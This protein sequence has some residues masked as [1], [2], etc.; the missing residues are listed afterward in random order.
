MTARI[1]I[2][3]MLLLILGST[4]QCTSAQAANRQTPAISSDRNAAWI[5]A[6]A[7]AGPP[8]AAGTGIGDENKLLSDSRFTSLLK[9]SFPQK[10]WFWYDHWKLTPLPEMMQIF[11]GVPGNT[12]LD[13]NRYVTLDGCVP[14]D[15]YM[16]RGM[17]W[18]DT[19]SNPAVLIFAGINPVSSN[20]PPFRSHL[21]IYPSRKLNW[22]QIPAS[23]LSSLH[24]WL[25]TIGA[26]HYMGTD[27]YRYDFSMATIVQPDG[28][29]EDLGTDIL[30]LPGTESKEK[31]GAKPGAGL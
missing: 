27:G 25:A 23:Y 10:Q 15:C 14:H 2:F 21:W 17:I 29:M 7:A 19:E 9:S 5:R 11:M 3:G 26:D 28:I 22:Q 13:D 24:R 16:N 6:F 18:I 31:S 20:T 12:V 4:S 1:L 8:S 30:G